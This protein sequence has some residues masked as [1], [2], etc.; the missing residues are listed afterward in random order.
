MEND[1]PAAVY[2]PGTGDGGE[3]HQG[4]AAADTAGGIG[5]YV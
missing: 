2:Q 1:Q 4:K 3:Q 5:Q